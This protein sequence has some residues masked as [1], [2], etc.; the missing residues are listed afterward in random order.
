VRVPSDG[1]DPAIAAMDEDAEFEEQASCYLGDALRKEIGDQKNEPAEVTAKSH[2]PTPSLA[3]GITASSTST[4]ASCPC[5]SPQANPRPKS[6]VDG[7]KFAPRGAGVPGA[8]TMP[9]ADR[10]KAAAAAARAASTLHP[11]AAKVTPAPQASHH[12]RSLSRSLN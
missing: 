8:P 12:R 11:G 4:Q 10:I 7:V 6:Q 9:K 1:I 2:S 5:C 3:S